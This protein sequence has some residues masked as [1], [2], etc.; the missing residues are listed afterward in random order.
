MQRDE[1]VYSLTHDWVKWLHTKKF[2]APA[3]PKNILEMLQQNSGGGECPDARLSEEL[4]AFNSAFWLHAEDEK[5][6]LPFLFVYADIRPKPAKTIAG[7][8]G[9]GRQYFYEKAHDTAKAILKTQR[10]IL[11]DRQ[12]NDK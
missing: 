10:N 3:Q 2:F 1:T 12:F 11:F 4:S 6:I 8:L 9:F 7:E 5:N